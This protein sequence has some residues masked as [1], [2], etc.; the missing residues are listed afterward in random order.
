MPSPSSSILP[1]LH[2]LPPHHHR[3][4][5]PVVE[6]DRRGPPQ[7]GDKLDPKGRDMFLRGRGWFIFLNR[8]SASFHPW[9][10]DL[11]SSKSFSQRGCKSFSQRGC[12]LDRR[13]PSLLVCI[14]RPRWADGSALLL[15]ESVLEYFVSE[16]YT[17]P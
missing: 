9:N 17:A 2:P 15:S 12:K 16:N 14:F 13:R 7:D 3:D 1:P 5:L 6:V 10:W 8:F 11:L 4:F